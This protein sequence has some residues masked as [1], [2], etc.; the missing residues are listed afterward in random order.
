MI[1]KDRVVVDT[2]VFI[3][4]LINNKSSQ[5]LSFF[6]ENDIT[7]Y[8]SI[9]LWDEFFEVL[10]KKKIKDRIPANFWTDK[11]IFKEATKV[12]KI[13]KTFNRSPDPDDNFLFDIAYQSKSYYIITEER[14]LQNMKHVGRIQVVSFKELKKLF[15]VI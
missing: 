13:E 6:I 8:S 10:N 3:S 2:N 1:P 14:A 9:E 7:I 15:K 12:I 5:L 4:Y 11:N